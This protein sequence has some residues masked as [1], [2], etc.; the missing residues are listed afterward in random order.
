MA[1]TQIASP[2]SPNLCGEDRHRRGP[3]SEDIIGLEFRG[4]DRPVSAR[5]N[6]YVELNIRLA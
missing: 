4:G 3:M 1:P 5:D 6:T 2:A